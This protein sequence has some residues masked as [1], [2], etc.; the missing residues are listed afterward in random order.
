MGET[1]LFGIVV[2][3]VIVVLTAY[4]F[5]RALGQQKDSKQRD[6]DDGEV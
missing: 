5:L 1:D 4:I 3:A 2:V 6:A